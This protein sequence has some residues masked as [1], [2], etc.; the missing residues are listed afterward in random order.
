MNRQLQAAGC[1]VEAYWPLL[2]AGAA[3]KGR[4]VDGEENATACNAEAKMINNVGMET[5]IKPGNQ[6][7]Q[8]SRFF[9]FE[10]K[11]C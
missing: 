11:G 8:T 1:S 10:V 9:L 7:C 6:F 2:M 4:P 5:L 3:Q